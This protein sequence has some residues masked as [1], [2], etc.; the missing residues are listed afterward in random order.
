M[1]PVQGPIGVFIHHNTLHA[2]QHLPFEEAVVAASEV[3]GTEPFMSEVAYREQLAKGR[4]REEDLRAV[5][6]REANE[7]ILPGSLDRRTLRTTLLRDGQVDFDAA[8]IDWMLEENDI[9]EPE[10][11]GLFDSCLALVEPSLLEGPPPARPRDGLLRI[12]GID[13]DEVIHPLLIR[14]AAV[15]LDQGVAYW[16]MPDRQSGFLHSIRSLMSPG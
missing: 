9:L 5:V 3:F 13:L 10:G 14:L 4:I 11:R 8:T 7:A 16:P 6:N 2:F 1:L 15:F 12:T